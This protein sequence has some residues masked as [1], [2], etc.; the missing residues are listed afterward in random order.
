M[1]LVKNNSFL[2]FIWKTYV[3]LYNVV[4]NYLHKE[5]LTPKRKYYFFFPYLL[6][7]ISQHATFVRG[8]SN[9]SLIIIGIK[10]WA[11]FEKSAYKKVDFQKNASSWFSLNN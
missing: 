10:I 8:S 4:K 1:K 6:L 7:P 2:S 9:M 5:M 11:R 3:E